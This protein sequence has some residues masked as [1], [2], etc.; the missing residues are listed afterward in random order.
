MK[1]YFTL[2]ST[3]YE[4]PCAQVGQPRY[5]QQALQECRRFMQL[6]RRKFGPEPEGAALRVQA[7]PHDFGTYYEVVCE[8]D[9]DLRA[10]VEYALRCDAETPATWEEDPENGLALPFLYLWHPNTTDMFSGY[11]LALAPAHLVGLVLIDRPHPAD[12]AWLAEIRATFGY[13]QL[14]AMTQGGE[15]GMVCQMHI[16]PESMRYLKRCDHPLTAA[17][18][19]SLLPLLSHL[20]AVT[21]ALGWDQHIGLWVSTIVQE[22]Q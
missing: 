21:L 17:L 16:A 1:D 14:A 5:R 4:E 2:G 13:Y 7:F 3:P 6:L 18:H 8:F 19:T 15:R 20:P 10:S 22:V 11:G 12:P 9:P